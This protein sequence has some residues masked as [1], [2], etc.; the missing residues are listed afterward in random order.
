MDR[1]KKLSSGQLYDLG[2]PIYR[3]EYPQRHIL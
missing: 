3:G 1:V 2:E